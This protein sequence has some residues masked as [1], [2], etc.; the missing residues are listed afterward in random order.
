VRKKRKGLIISDYMLKR[1]EVE[2]A[3]TDSMKVM[4]G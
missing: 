2:A 1:G 3:H 4:S